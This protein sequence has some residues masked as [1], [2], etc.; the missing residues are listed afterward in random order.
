MIFFDSNSAISYFCLPFYKYLALAIFSTKIYRV[1]SSFLLQIFGFCYAFKKKTLL[2]S[3][4][5]F[6][7]F[8]DIILLL[9]FLLISAISYF[10]FY[11]YKYLPLSTF[12]PNSAVS[13]FRLCLFHPPSKNLPFYI[14]FKPLHYILSLCLF[15]IVCIFIFPFISKALYDILEVPEL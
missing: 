5:V 2:F 3:I 15:F 9:F 13:Y 7:F 6:F 10:R 11:F 1:F 4:F 14:F 8:I 12:L